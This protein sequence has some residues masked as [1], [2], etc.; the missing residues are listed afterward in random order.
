MGSKGSAN[1]VYSS[2]SEATAALELN[3][4][5]MKGNSRY[6]D[7]I[8]GGDRSPIRPRRGLRV[9]ARAK[10]GWKCG[11]LGPCPW[12]AYLGCEAER[13]WQ[14]AGRVQARAKARRVAT[15]VTRTRRDQGECLCAA[16]TL[17]R[18][19]NS[20]RNIWL[21]Q[22]PSTPFTGSTRAMLLWY[23]RRRHRR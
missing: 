18:K 4:S 23:T 10:V 22:A 7:V 1:V 8:I 5:T 16:S 9:A 12:S 17:E 14:W 11:T 2:A 20:L 3:G 19:T 21:K 6:I 13:A 15:T